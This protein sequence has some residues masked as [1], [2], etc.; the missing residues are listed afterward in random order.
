MHSHNG[1]FVQVLELQKRWTPFLYLLSNV[2]IDTSERCPRGDRIGAGYKV[3][4]GYK[5]AST[6]LGRKRSISRVMQF[7]TSTVRATKK[8]HIVKQDF[9]VL[10]VFEGEGD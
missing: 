6:K 5:A 10:E 9:Q 3:F 1:E 2:S 7:L 4:P 8:S